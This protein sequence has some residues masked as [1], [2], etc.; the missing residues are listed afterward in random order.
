[1]RK[2]C[3]WW[4]ERCVSFGCFKLYHGLAHRRGRGCLLSTS[5]SGG[6]GKARTGMCH[7][8]CA[9]QT[10]P[11]NSRP[12]PHTLHH[13]VTS[14]RTAHHSLAF[15]RVF[16]LPS[17]LHLPYSHSIAHQGNSEWDMVVSTAAS[18]LQCWQHSN[19]WVNRELSDKRILLLVN[20]T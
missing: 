12:L 20:S 7:V 10:K 11:E 3:G 9:L 1:M 16:C 19:R 18:P 4:V 15:L 13:I 6:V 5:A 14:T 17:F 2:R 8:T